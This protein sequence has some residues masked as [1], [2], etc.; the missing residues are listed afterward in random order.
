M[1][2]K[3]LNVGTPVVLQFDI[4]WYVTFFYLWPLNRRS[5]KKVTVETFAC[6]T[7]AYML[8]PLVLQFDIV[9]NLTVFDLWP[10][11]RMSDEEVTVE[12]FVRLTKAYKLALLVWQFDDV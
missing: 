3:G 4:I 6:L 2:D 9:W 7:N 5:D 12:T 8:E 10:L 1:F 11:N